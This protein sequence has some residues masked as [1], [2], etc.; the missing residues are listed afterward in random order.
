VLKDN[1]NNTNKYCNF[2]DRVELG[3]KYIKSTDFS[4]IPNGTYEID[5]KNVFA[6]VQDYMTKSFDDAKFEA[7]RKYIDI[8]YIIQ[9]AERICVSDI[10]NFTSDVPYS[11]ENDIEFLKE[12]NNNESKPSFLSVK[13]NEFVLLTPNDAHMPS[14][15]FDKNPSYVKK[16]V[17]KVLV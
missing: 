4:T 3:F 10:R 15:N 17:V 2:S 13:Q 1:I 5:G 6:S 7:H 14:V 12:I 16:V 11:N 9:G 8:Q